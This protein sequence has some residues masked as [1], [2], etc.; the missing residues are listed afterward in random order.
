MDDVSVVSQSD[1]HLCFLSET[2]GSHGIR[3]MPILKRFDGVGNLVFMIIDNIDNSNP[4]RLDIVYFIPIS[5]QIPD[6]PFG[7]EETFLCPIPGPDN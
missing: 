5:D 4:P 7:N 2:S 6:F 3:K 1:P